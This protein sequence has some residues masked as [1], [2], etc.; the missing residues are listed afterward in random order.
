MF[1]G[2]RER[3]HREQMGLKK[4]IW[5]IYL[6][7]QVCTYEE[8]RVKRS[9]QHLGVIVVATLALVSANTYLTDLFQVALTFCL[10]ELIVVIL[11]FIIL[12]TV[13]Y[14]TD[15]RYLCARSWTSLCIFFLLVGDL[16][17]R[18]LV[19]CFY[20]LGS[21]KSPRPFNYWKFSNDIFQSSLFRFTSSSDI[22]SHFVNN[23]CGVGKMTSKELP[24]FNVAWNFVVQTSTPAGYLFKLRKKHF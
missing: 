17:K 6:R 2:G 13:L 16:W 7:I 15:T 24:E 20:D 14:D 23:Y 12:I 19:K 18:I 10:Q 21:A 3:V 8:Q 22:K 1:S 4:F 5:R 11:Y 9:L